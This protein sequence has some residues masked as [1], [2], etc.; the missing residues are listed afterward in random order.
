VFPGGPD[1]ARQAVGEGDS[2]H[3]VSALTFTLQSPQSEVIQ[4]MPSALLAMRGQ[5]CRARTVN[6]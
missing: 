6:Q 2:C 3:V 1:D 5:E 4:G